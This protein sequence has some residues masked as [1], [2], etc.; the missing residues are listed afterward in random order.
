MNSHKINRIWKGIGMKQEIGRNRQK[1]KKIVKKLW[2]F[3]PLCLLLSGGYAVYAKYLAQSVQR[4]ITIASSI[5]FTCN[6]ASPSQTAD[7]MT[8][9]LVSVAQSTDTDGKEY[10]FTV[11]IRNY[12]NI[13]L[14][15]SSTA[16][17][18]YTVEFWLADAGT[19]GDTYQAT[20]KVKTKNADGILEEMTE[21]KTI[22]QD[23]E[24]LASFSN[25]LT[26][27]EARSDDYNIVVTAPSGKAVPIYVRVKTADGALLTELLKGKIMLQTRSDDGKFLKSFGFN[28]NG[29]TPD[30]QF[31]YL[32]KQSEFNY[33][34]TTGG[35]SQEDGGNTEMVTL[36]WNGTIYDIDR[37][38]SAWLAWEKSGKTAPKTVEKATLTRYTD[39][40]WT[41][42][43]GEDTIYAI[44]VPVNAYASINIGF[45]R[46]TGYDSRVKSAKAQQNFV[47]VVKGNQI[48]D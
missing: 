33:K 16:Q 45:F 28:T 18:P 7:D 19:A 6:Y 2:F 47:Y 27:G 21:T 44:T 48:S 39:W 20:A 25:I 5:Y 32:Q 42:W 38:S 46:E 29:D 8:D 4:G 36:Y 17:I 10:N 35:V 3:L 24:H 31:Q 40:D 23:K 30:E 12:E 13:L 15:N 11:E 41:E 14:Y 37:F 26:G 1:I 34:I 43:R 9:A 22:T